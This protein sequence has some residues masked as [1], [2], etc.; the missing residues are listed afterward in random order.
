MQEQAARQ[1]LAALHPDTTPRYKVTVHLKQHGGFNERTTLG[2]RFAGHEGYQLRIP[3]DPNVPLL[4]NDEPVPWRVECSAS[5]DKRHGQQAIVRVTL[6]LPSEPA[7]VTVDPD[8][9]LLGDCPTN[10][11]WRLECGWRLTPAYTQL[12]ETD[13]TNAYD[14]WNVI[15]GPW[16]F[17]ASYNDPW[18]VRTAEFGLRAGV[19]RTQNFAGGV[20]LG[21]RA[22]DRN[23]VVG[24]DGVWDHVLLPH[25]Q[26]G[27]TVEQSIATLGPQDIRSSRATCST[28]AMSSCTATRCTSSRSTMSKPSVCLRTVAC[29]TPISS[30]PATTPSTTDPPSAPHYHLNLLTPYWDAQG[31]LM[32][33]ASYQYGLPLFGNTRTFPGVVRPS[34]DRQADAAGL[35]LAAHG[36]A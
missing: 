17:A 22:D 15:F 7:Q 13:M 16:A 1:P 6:L 23:T 30:C 26:I 19:Y 35:Q 31:G 36:G 28:A 27:Y 24:A 2:I 3:I 32:L 20:Y 33:D 21:Y 12:E 10:N 29:P 34:V 4:Q 8:H 14:R 11:H 5:T 25:G 9:L 18:F